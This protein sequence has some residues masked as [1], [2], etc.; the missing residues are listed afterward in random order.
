M[1]LPNRCTTTLAN[2]AGRLSFHFRLYEGAVL[3]T[4]SILQSG[5]GGLSSA[6]KEAGTLAMRSFA[7]AGLFGLAA[8]AVAGG[9]LTM[10]NLAPDRPVSELTQR[11]AQPPSCFVDIA[12]MA[13]HLRDEGIPYDP[14]PIVLIHGTSSSLHTWAGWVDALKGSRR[15]ITF[16]LPG[17]G[18]TGPSLDGRYTA[19]DYVAFMRKFFDAFGIRKCVLGGNSLGGDVAWQ[20]AYAMPDRVEKLILVDAGGYPLNPSSM[21][22]A[23]RIANTPVVNHLMEKL[24]PRRLVQDS[25]INVYGDPSKLKS[26]TVDLYYDM[27]LREGN[28]RALIQRFQQTDFGSHADRIATLTVPTLIVWGGRDQ[29]IPASNAERFHRDIQGSQLALFQDLGHVPQEEDPGQTVS[30]VKVFLN[31]P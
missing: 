30:A 2:V 5:A 29:L 18:L 15:V 7:R 22:L 26:E 17:F 9:T 16:D 21:P 24:L 6:F 25:L 27:A 28:R 14:S 31:V 8:L 13:V 23:F 11:W 10:M 19:D 4:P 3:D 1:R 20:T 12:G